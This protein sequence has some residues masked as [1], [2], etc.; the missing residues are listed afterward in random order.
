[1]KFSAALFDLDGTLQDSEIHW[2]RATQAFLNDNGIAYN[3]SA[4]TALVY[5][6]SSTEIYNEIAAMPPFI[7]RSVLDLAECIRGYYARMTQ[8][9]DISYPSS[10][11]LLKRM[12]QDMPV[13]IVSGSPKR[14][15]A[16]AARNLGVADDLSL[17]L[18]AEDVARGKPAPDGFL[19]AAAALGVEPAWCVVFEDSA[20]GVAAAKAA[21]MFCV[22]VSRPGRPPQDV[23]AADIVVG[24]L[25]EF[26]YP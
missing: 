7:G 2:I 24:D 25:A 20:A 15:V 8:V 22:A 10:V 26:H 12:A 17:V 1:M 9:T 18:G 13:A 4:T 16:A 23:G 19:Q 11:A 21:G 3:L 5:G 6:R 14:D